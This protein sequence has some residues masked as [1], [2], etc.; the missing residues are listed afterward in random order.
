MPDLYIVLLTGTG[1]LIALVAW[2]PVLL[3]K[4]PLS[5]PIVCLGIGAALFS[6]PQVTISPLPQDHP[7]IAERLTEFVVIV[8][9]MGA[10]LKIDRVFALRRWHVTWRLLGI[11]MMLSIAG[12]F[13]LGVWG[14]GLG[15]AASILLA[16]SLAPTDPVLAS[17]IQVGT[18]TEGQE[19]EVRFGLTSE[20]GLNDG[21]AFPFVNLAIALS[22]AA[23][24]GDP[25]WAVKW[26]TYNVLWEIGAGLGVGWLI[27]VAFG[28]LTFRIPAVSRLAKTGDGFIALA[29]T[30]LSYGIT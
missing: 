14:L 9:L 3:K 5:L 18:P 13:A 8:A 1:L 28:W 23:A 4:A 19:D 2:L 24:T 17:D 12:I 10:G 27:G 16:G 29:A 20:A 22:L 11:T 15:V 7:E 30:F 25:D 6:L 21:L 26:L